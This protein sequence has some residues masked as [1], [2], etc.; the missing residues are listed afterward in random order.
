MNKNKQTFKE[1][2]ILLVDDFEGICEADKIRE[3]E[4]VKLICYRKFIMKS[5]KDELGD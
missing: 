4:S 1:R 5:L 2:L 3:L